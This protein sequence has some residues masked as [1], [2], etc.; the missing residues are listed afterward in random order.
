MKDD[1]FVTLSI[2]VVFLLG[3]LWAGWA[4]GIKQWIHGKVN[5]GTSSDTGAPQ[6]KKAGQPY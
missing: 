4:N 3:L 2:S 5:E 6:Q 1:S